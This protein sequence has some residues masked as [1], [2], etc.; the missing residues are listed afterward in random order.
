MAVDYVFIQPT[1]KKPIFLLDR[2]KLIDGKPM[3]INYSQDMVDK[4]VF[5]KVEKTA[6]VLGRAS[7]EKDI[8]VFT[9]KEDIKYSSDDY[10]RDR[11]KE[12]EV[13]EETNVER[14]AEAVVES[15]QAFNTAVEKSV[16]LKGTGKKTKKVPSTI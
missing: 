4:G 8:V 1:E 11:N 2:N 10:F 12:I 7:T 9:N 6:F 14:K 13:A 16:G 3:E 15:F 5:L